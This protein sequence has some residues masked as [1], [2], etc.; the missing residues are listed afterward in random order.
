MLKYKVLLDVRFIVLQCHF[1]LPL[2]VGAL[3]LAQQLSRM[4]QCERDFK[5]VMSQ[6]P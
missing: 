2:I 5:F 4:E 3:I 1:T 6:E